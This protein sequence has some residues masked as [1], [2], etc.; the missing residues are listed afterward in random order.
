MQ[1]ILK[2]AIEYARDGFPV[3]QLIAY[4]WNLNVDVLKTFKNFQSV[5][6]PTPKEGD[7]FRNPDLARTLEILSRKGKQAYHSEMPQ[8]LVG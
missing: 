1:S 7:I 5:F 2:P 6:M 4:Y 3:T 8:S